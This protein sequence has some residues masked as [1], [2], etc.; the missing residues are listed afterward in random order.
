MFL[1]KIYKIKAGQK[2]YTDQIQKGRQHTHTQHT[3]HIHHLW[4]TL[5]IP[6]SVKSSR[7]NRIIRDLPCS[8][9]DEKIKEV[10]S[11]RILKYLRQEIRWEEGRGWHD[12]SGGRQAL[13]CHRSVPMTWEA[14]FIGNQRVSL[15]ATNQKNQ[16]VWKF[17]EKLKDSKANNWLNLRK[18][19]IWGEPKGHVLLQNWTG[20]RSLNFLY[21]IVEVSKTGFKTVLQMLQIYAW[22][23]FHS[24]NS[25]RSYN[26]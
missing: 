17:S 1:L 21:Q 20:P 12:G 4:I 7:I 14:I 9:K 13:P 19:A 25:T 26:F 8:L 2:A 23:H 5:S 11:E 16:V 22:L 10:C 15:T 24:F 18:N 6:R 3:Q